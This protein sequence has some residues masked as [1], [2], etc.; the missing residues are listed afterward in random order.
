[1]VDILQGDAGKGDSA[2]LARGF[3]AAN[4]SRA[5]ELDKTH[6]LDSARYLW[7]GYEVRDVLDVC[8][9]SHKTIF[10]G[11]IR[12]DRFFWCRGTFLRRFYVNNSSNKKNDFSTLSESCSAQLRSKMARHPTGDGW[13]LFS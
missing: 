6:A 13:E 3:E 2:I 10:C 12:C 7:W 1:V 11:E 5:P 9:F 8:P 4:F